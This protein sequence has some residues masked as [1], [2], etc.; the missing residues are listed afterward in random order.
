MAYISIRLGVGLVRI[1]TRSCEP[2]GPFLGA[3]KTHDGHKRESVS[4]WNEKRRLH[5]RV[6]SA[7]LL[8]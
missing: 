4:E 8:D 3:R 7:I 5:L 1:V 6:T 2:E